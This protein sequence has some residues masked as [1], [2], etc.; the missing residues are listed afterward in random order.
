M[1]SGDELVIITEKERET[2]R[3][4]GEKKTRERKKVNMASI[5]FKGEFSKKVITENTRFN[6]E[7]C[8][9]CH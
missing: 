3:E 9:D 6:N 2:E 5:N 8:E 7:K 1:P 4:V